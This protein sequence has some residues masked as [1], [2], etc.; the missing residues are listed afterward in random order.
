[1]TQQSYSWVS[2][3]EKN[4]CISTQGPIHMFRATLLVIAPNVHNWWMNKQIVAYLYHG[5]L[6]GPEKEWNTNTCY[7]IN[8]PQKYHARWKK[9]DTKDHSVWKISPQSKSIGT[10]C[11]LVVAW[12]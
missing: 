2:M 8:E 10:D 5:V 4:E 1:M 9:L 11:R 7:N 12:G 3:Q 6:F